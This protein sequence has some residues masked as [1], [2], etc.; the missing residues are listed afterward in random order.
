MGGPAQE[1]ARHLLDHAHRRPGP[2]RRVPVRRLLGQGR[3]PRRRLRPRLLRGLGR[4]PDHRVPHRHLHLPP[5]L[6][7]LLGRDPR[8]RRGAA[9]HPRVAARHDHPAG[10]A[11]HPG[12]L[13]LGLLVG[14][15][16]EGG[17]IHTL[18]GARVLPPGAGALRLGRHR[19]RAHAALARHRARRRVPWPTC[20]TCARR[21][22]RGASPSAFP[23]PTRRRST[24]CTWTRSTPWRPIGATVGLSP[25]AVDLR[26][27]QG[28]RRRGE[29]PRR[30]VGAAR[31]ALRPLQTGR[32][33]NY[34]MGVFAGMFV[35]V[36]VLVWFW[37]S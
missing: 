4:G 5:H 33:Q 26:R 10:A 14:W 22:C 1:D 25:L 18:P 29:R 28:H 8:R 20:S 6:H 34:A 19:R 31:Q 7:D 17:W 15:P 12:S 35:L 24:R 9:P 21:P 27:H 36:V 30:R 16:P 23:W 13:C 2:R 3:D 37:G 11:R 32:V